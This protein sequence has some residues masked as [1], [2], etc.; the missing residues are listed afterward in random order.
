MGSVDQFP[1]SLEQQFLRLQHENDGSAGGFGPR[2]ISSGG[3]R[4]TGP[5]DRVKFEQALGDVVTRHEALRTTIVSDADG[6]RQ[7]I[8][9]PGPPAVVYRDLADSSGRSHQDLAEEFLNEVESGTFDMTQVPNLWVHIGRLDDQDHVVVLVSHLPIVDVWSLSLVMRDS[10]E[11]YAARLDGRKPEMPEPTPYRE[12]VARQHDESGEA[13]AQPSYQFWRDDLRGARP[14]T[15]PTDHP[16]SGAGPSGTR[17]DRFSIDA[18][19]GS[20]ALEFA[21][22]MR[23]SPFMVLFAAYRVHLLG[24]TGMTD[25]V[26]W[27]LSS[28]PGRRRRW[29]E[30]TV[31]YFV[32]LY[33]L[34][35]DI[36]DCK[37]FRDVVTRVRQTSLAA[38]KHEIPFVRLVAE[39]SE[40]IGELE[41]GDQITERARPGFQMSP[42][43]YV[44]RE[45]T[46][47]GVGCVAVQRRVS[48]RV[49]PDIPDD[50]ILWTVELG[51]SGE[52]IFAINSSIDRFDQSTM[53]A[54]QADFRNVLSA[55]VHDPDTPLSEMPA[56]MSLAARRE[57]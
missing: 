38:F 32:N 29:M 26:V 39:A 42:N 31:G 19:L 22:S 56:G 37:T 20:A 55:G 48:Q 23:C 25:G 40:A 45:Q 12:Y 33:P 3:W 28:G 24:A 57:S 51:P 52:L 7:E 47:G 8:Q 27:T 50:A 2:P 13:K 18:E 46:S 30:N 9:P 36:A 17:C 21:R 34:R 11:L 16:P 41:Q 4:V 43:P 44:L 49:G 5:F 6:W 15:L 54:M 1:F 14:I 53:D 10:V 35:T